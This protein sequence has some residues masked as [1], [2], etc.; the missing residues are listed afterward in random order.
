MIE[1]ILWRR[2]SCKQLGHQSEHTENSVVRNSSSPVVSR[3]LRFREVELKT[4]NK[5]LIRR[6]PKHFDVFNSLV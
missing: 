4:L 5:E 1:A 3:T 2:L 6:Q